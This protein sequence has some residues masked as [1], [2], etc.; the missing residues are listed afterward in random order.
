MKHA[1][2]RVRVEEPDFSELPDESYDW[3]HS[4]Y[5]N[6]HEEIHKD[7]PKLSGDIFGH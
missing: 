4:I 7:N 1:T 3:D 5:G 6:V 2:I